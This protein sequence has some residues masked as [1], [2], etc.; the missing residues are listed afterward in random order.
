LGPAIRY[1]NE[2]GE[3]WKVGAG[4]GFEDFRDERLQNGGGGVASGANPR[5]RRRTTSPS[6][7][8]T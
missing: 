4:F 8:V 2:W 1:K 7:N 5:F 3:N 6:C